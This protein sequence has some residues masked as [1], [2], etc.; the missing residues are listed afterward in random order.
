MLLEQTFTKLKFKNDL[1]KY[2]ILRLKWL[3]LII[4][5]QVNNV[6]IEINY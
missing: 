3:L 6:D 4:E 2:C 1:S 5:I